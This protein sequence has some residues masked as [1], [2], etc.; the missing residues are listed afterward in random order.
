MLKK[1]ETGVDL[2]LVSKL[3]AK[4]ICVAL[5]RVRICPEEIPDSP[6]QVT[7]LDEDHMENEDAGDVEEN[8]PIQFEE[9]ASQEDESQSAAERDFPEK[10]SDSPL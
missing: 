3:F 2:R 6:Q 7:S 9:E 8:A 5:S 4:P 1:Y 10:E